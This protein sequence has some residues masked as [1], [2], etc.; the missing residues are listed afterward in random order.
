MKKGDIVKFKE[1]TDEEKQA[2]ESGAV[3]MKVLWVDEPRAMVEHMEPKL[4][5]YPTTIYNI[6][7]LEVLI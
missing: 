2:R 4:K 3:I 1:E 6:I 7:D 5:I